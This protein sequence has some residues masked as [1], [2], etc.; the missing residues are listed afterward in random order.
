MVAGHYSMREDIELKK[1]KRF[2][3]LDAFRGFTIAAMILVNTPGSWAYVYRPLKHAEWHG[4]MPADLVFPFFLFIVGASMWFSFKKFDHR[5][6]APAV[7]KVLRRTA[8]IF[9]IGLALSA[10]PFVRDYSTMRI[11]GV[12]Q[13][14][15]L[16][17]GIAAV[18]CLYFDR[19]KLIATSGIVLAGYWLLLR[20]LGGGDPYGLEGNLVRSIDMRVIGEG[21]LWRGAG[22]PFDPEGI[23][24]TLPA[25]VTVILGY[26][27]GRSIQ[28]RSGPVRA[29]YRMILW[30]ILAVLA[31]SAWNIVFPINKYLWTSSYVLYTAGIALVILAV[32]IWLVDIK[33]YRMW[34]R[35]LVVF[36]MN[37]IF[38]YVLSA[39]WVLTGIHIIKIPT[40][41]GSLVT[42]YGWL[43]NRVFVPLAGHFG[44]SLLFAVTHIVFYW[45]ILFILYRRKIFIK[46]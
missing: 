33:G 13:R 22:V 45:L 41:D 29:V 16:A 3:A 19:K 8:I 24:S 31:G 37:S 32:F 23:L 11:M 34:A 6:S 42:G 1:A 39:L 30:G 20:G 4:C 18:L 35:P 25:V 9:I 14:I 46:I 21:R 12:L 27:T 40:G 17:Y 38:I 28:S 15:A 2:V 43:Y 5:G 44:G 26:L 10:F 36:G 7:K